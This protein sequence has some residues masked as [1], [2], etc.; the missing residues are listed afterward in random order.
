LGS[1]EERLAMG[2]ERVWTGD[3]PTGWERGDAGVTRRRL[4][5]GAAAGSLVLAGYGGASSAAARKRPQ[6]VVPRF[7][8]F[9]DAPYTD[10]FPSGDSQATLYV[11]PDG[12]IN[13]AALKATRTHS[14][15]YEF[16]DDEPIV[17]ARGSTTVSVIGGETF[18]LQTGDMAYFRNGIDTDITEYEDFLDLG[19]YLLIPRTKAPDDTAVP[20]FN[21]YDDARYKPTHQP[22]VSEALLYQSPDGRIR[23]SGLRSQNTKRRTYKYRTDQQIYIF[24]GSMKV[25]VHGGETFELGVGDMAYF[26]KGIVADISRSTDFLEFVVFLDPPLT[27]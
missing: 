16:P 20:H 9:D 4:V 25:S 2:N 1:P 13:A 5:A 27:P 21:V 3:R 10:H 6:I 15:H 8:V 24:E 18:T 14:Y 19:L 26:T 23:T 17:M 12:V 11:S 22:G 7:N